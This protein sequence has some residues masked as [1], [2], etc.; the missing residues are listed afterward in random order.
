MHTETNE[1]HRKLVRD[2]I[3]E[4]IL[5]AGDRPQWWPLADDDEY[6]NA[7]RSKVV[8]EAT[9]VRDASSSELVDELADLFEVVTALTNTLG[10]TE[11]QV[12]EAADRKRYARGGFANRIWLEQVELRTPPSK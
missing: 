11:T 10:V 1:V 5:N 7:L 12:R 4:R 2:K 8:E 6:L 9:E 3:P